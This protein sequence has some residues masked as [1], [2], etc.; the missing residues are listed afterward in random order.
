MHTRACIQ[1][2]ITTLLFGKA[3]TRSSGRHSSFTDAPLPSYT[4]ALARARARAPACA[5]ASEPTG[6]DAFVTLASRRPDQRFVAYGSGHDAAIE[7]KLGEL[8]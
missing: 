7:A 5:R 3:S 6:L 4:H 8:L 2:N 1:N